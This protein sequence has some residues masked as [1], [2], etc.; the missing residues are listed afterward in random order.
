MIEERN[1]GK[2]TMQLIDFTE[3]MNIEVGMWGRRAW[4]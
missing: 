1:E 4:R 3:C 2:R